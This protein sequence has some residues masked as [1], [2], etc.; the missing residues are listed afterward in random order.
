MQRHLTNFILPLCLIGAGIA[1]QADPA[2]EKAAGECLRIGNKLGSVSYSEC[3]ARGLH[4]SGGVSVN[5]APILIKEYP[6]LKRRTPLGRVLLVGGIHGD[7]YSSVSVV[8]KWLQTLDQHHSGLFHW[9]IVPLLNPD[10]LLQ[11]DSA[12]MNANGGQPR[13]RTGFT[14]P[15]GI[16]AVI[17]VL[18][19]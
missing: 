8:F 12:R 11:D 19:P 17:P 10:G 15:G 13:K 9:H 1:L 16:R 5:G 18:R 4:L 6:P 7:E 3:M 2:E 14:Q